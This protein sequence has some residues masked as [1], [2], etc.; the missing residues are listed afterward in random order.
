MREAV[1]THGTTELSGSSSVVT[2]DGLALLELGDEGAGPLGD[3]IEI[4]VDEDETIVHTSMRSCP[5]WNNW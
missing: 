2:V 3:V 5:R 1:A 4:P